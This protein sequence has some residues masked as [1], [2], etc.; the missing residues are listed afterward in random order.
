MFKPMVPYKPLQCLSYLVAVILLNPLIFCFACSTSM[1]ELSPLGYIH[2][3]S[4]AG[5]LSDI[6]ISTTVKLNSKSVWYSQP[7]SSWIPHLNNWHYHMT[8]RPSQKQQ[9]NIVFKVRPYKLIYQLIRSRCSCGQNPIGRKTKSFHFTYLKNFS[10]PHELSCRKCLSLSV[11][12]V[13]LGVHHF[14]KAVFCEPFPWSVALGLES[15]L[16]ESHRKP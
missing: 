10:Q 6:I 16:V 15:L 4:P 8:S 14:A 2:L 1:S 5:N 12:L 9:N 13:G 3:Q 7:S 11:G